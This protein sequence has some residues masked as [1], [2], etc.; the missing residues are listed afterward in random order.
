MLEEMGYAQASQDPQ[1]RKLY[2]LTP[3]GEKVLAD[4]K[5]QIDAIFERF[6]DRDDNRGAGFVS[7]KR[8]MLNLRSALQLRLRGREASPEQIQAIVDALDAAA[9]VIERA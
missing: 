6:G 2:G 8:A 7:V 9:K 1:G 4:N 5:A 3:E